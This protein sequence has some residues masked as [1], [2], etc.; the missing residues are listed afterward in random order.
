MMPSEKVKF[1][2]RLSHVPEGASV[3]CRFSFVLV[4][5]QA[6]AAA[7][8]A[9][10][11]ALHEEVRELIAIVGSKKETREEKSAKT[12]SMF[13]ILDEDDAS[14]AVI[15]LRVIESFHDSLASM[16]IGPGELRNVCFLYLV[17]PRLNVGEEVIPVLK[18]GFAEMNFMYQS[19]KGKA[20]GTKV[21]TQ[22]LTHRGPAAALRT[23]SKTPAGHPSALAA[24]DPLLVQGDASF[25][26]EVASDD[27]PDDVPELRPFCE[28]LN[29][30]A[31]ASHSKD[32]R[33]K[34]NVDDGDALY[35]QFQ[36]LARDMFAANLRWMRASSR[37][38][39][40]DVTTRAAS[41]CCSLQ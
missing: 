3:R 29:Q 31:M 1:Q 20:S 30:V 11:C 18:Q 19:A 34:V 38:S 7:N 6:K 40:M 2:L 17:D 14:I 32:R 5:P 39:F 28:M 21:R 15:T 35:A 12:R 22:I 4:G 41:G 9:M 27:D 33:C 26:G 8:R 25:L 10:Q 16:Q 24:K 36:R 13:V 37:S 23:P